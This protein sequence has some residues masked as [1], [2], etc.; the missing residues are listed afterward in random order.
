MLQLLIRILHSTM[1]TRGYILVI[2]I[3]LS[4]STTNCSCKLIYITPDERYT[5]PGNLQ[6]CYTLSG[7]TGNVYSSNTKIVFL[8]GNHTIE[9]NQSIVIA[10]ASN[11]TLEGEG[12]TIQC[13]NN[14]EIGFVFI[15]IMNL[16]IANL[17]LDQCGTSLL[18]KTKLQ[19]YRITSLS[20]LLLHN[21][22]FYTSNSPAL[23]L[24]QV[25]DATISGVRIHNSTG[26]GLLG[27]NVLGHST[28]TKSYLIMNNPNCVFL[29]M[30]TVANTSVLS[31][32]YSE[33]LFGILKQNQEDKNS[34]LTTAAGLSVIAAQNLYDIT[35]IASNVLMQGNNGTEY[36]NFLFRVAENNEYVITIQLH[37]INCSHSKHSGLVL[38]IRHI[39]SYFYNN[40]NKKNKSILTISQSYFGQN[41]K[42]VVMRRFSS[43]PYNSVRLE[44]VIFS[45][46]SL[47]LWLQSTHAVLENIN[48]TT[49]TAQKGISAPINIDNCNVR[50]IGNSTF[51]E[52]KGSM[53]AVLLQDSSV[54]FEGNTTF[55][56]NKGERAGAIYA[57][58][59][60][61]YFQDDMQ[62]IENEGYN[63]GAIAF[64]EGISVI[65]D[66]EYEISYSLT[67]AQNLTAHFTRN[68]ARH[69]G[70]AIYIEK[71]EN[72]LDTDINIYRKVQR[73][74][75]FYIPVYDEKNYS[76]N[77]AGLMF[78][79]NN[80]SDIAGSAI[81]GGWIRLCYIQKIFVFIQDVY[82]G[83]IFTNNTFQIETNDSD[84]S[85]V[86]SEPVRVCI[87]YN[88]KPACDTIS[89][90]ITAYPGETF[91]IYA[92]GIG[93]MYGTVPSSI[94][95][96]FRLTSTT[97][98]PQIENLQRVQKA[99]HFCT[100]LRY[101]VKSPNAVEDI[102]LTVE[103]NVNKDV[104]NDPLG[105]V[106]TKKQFVNVVVHVELQPCP[107][108]FV[109]NTTVC[110]CHP[111]LQELNIQCNITSARIL[112]ESQLWINATFSKEGAVG[113]LV[114]QNC[115]F[116]YCKA[117]SLHLSLENPDEQCA[118]NRSGT[119]CGA[120]QHNLSHVLGSLRCKRCSSF[121]SI[122]LIAAAAVAGLI[123]VV[124]LILLNFTVSEGTIS[125]LIFYANIVQANQAIF[126]PNDTQNTFLSWFIAWLN[127]DL[128]I[129]TCFY[130]GMDAYA[131]TWL[132]FIFPIYVWLIG[133]S[134]IMSSY[135]FTSAAKIAGRNAVQVFATL[136]FI[137]YA[138]LL[139]L[140]ITVLSSTS[141]EY[142]DGS[143]RRVWLY[144]GNVDYLKGKH[145]PLFMAAVLL[146]LLFF[147]PYTTLLLC[148]QCIR[149]KPWLRIR[150]RRLKPLL[151]A[152]TG[153]Y[154]DKCH[155]WTGLLLILRAILFLIFSVNA[156]GDPAINLFAIVAIVLLL[157]IKAAILNGVYKIRY[158]SILEY[159]F[160][161]NLGT[162]SVASLYTRLTNG[163]Q[164]AC[165][166]TSVSIA[167][168]TFCGIVIYHTIIASRSLN[169][170][171]TVLC[172]HRPTARQIRPDQ[173]SQP[174]DTVNPP[175]PQ[176][177]PVTFIQL[178]E[179]LLEPCE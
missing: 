87:C 82:P 95:A 91:Q 117:H 71:T 136:L 151:E 172:R 164:T 31:I 174:S 142:P 7:I 13:N 109:M 156:L 63:G 167:F 3:V 99:E 80:T 38:D 11:I 131:K 125:G 106:Y 47:A 148:I 1:N 37:H 97:I 102:I 40:R 70:G 173:E 57:K 110:I 79:T 112:R 88:M 93:Q 2:T 41:T 160:M 28:V 9:T 147:L 100:Y 157:F 119:L 55:L 177:V 69:Y 162:L 114:H 90:T 29:F 153:P 89:Y 78:F 92:V 140:I 19:I 159:I 101:T 86:S 83:F 126:F 5:C 120:C 58:G 108:G 158:F 21:E 75:C 161:L 8:P 73:Q 81:Y 94:N 145:I 116:G 127:L 98:Q 53:A 22:N 16:S 46:N 130:N 154:K 118:L 66:F 135:Y 77:N 67:I 32:H 65:K 27:F 168:T 33:F 175:I 52:N 104:L 166:Y 74:K 113:I 149:L 12:S 129:E 132:Q 6:Q 84:L 139:R 44:N 60:Q 85:P 144:D 146:L 42:A 122:A 61:L 171:V 14:R 163:N 64:Y 68:H 134:A 178:R 26:P 179:P 137:S 105:N 25:T 107:L 176:Q 39:S 62:F 59:S 50:V 124:F 121:W 133:I 96:R 20:M 128:G 115:P 51:R 141:L 138:K 143:A 76:F 103:S 48:F 43:S 49:N 169:S 152:Y 155:Y 45:K 54:W 34:S 17:H 23:Y 72:Y 24:I 30:D 111:R 35:I 18:E 123:L 56:R 36:G 150:I 165:T 15:E 10:N 170:Y 4:V